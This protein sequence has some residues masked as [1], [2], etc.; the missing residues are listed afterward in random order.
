MKRVFLLILCALTLFLNA[1]EEKKVALLFLTRSNLNHPELW[2]DWI[3]EEKYNVYNHAK[4]EVTDP[5]FSQF[6]IDE[7]QPNEWG[8]LIYAQ[9][10]LLRAAVKDPENYKF[11]FLSESTIPLRTS[12]EVYDYLTAEEESYMSWMR[13]WWPFDTKRILREF[14]REYHLGNH[15]WIILNR[16]HAEMFAEDDYWIHLAMR[17]I[18][19]DESYPSTFYNMSGVLGEFKNIFTTYVDFIHG[20]PYLFTLA[21]PENIKYLLDARNNTKGVYGE[22]YCLFAR[23]VAPEFPESVL[24]EIINGKIPK[25]LAESLPTKKK[26]RK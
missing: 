16:K 4:Y 3:D 21:T 14:P 7:T 25:P 13:I 5:W 22:Q 17:H 9:Q 10:A 24:R 6:R 11:V 15:Q 26:R 12:D 19:C 1:S 18:C 23:K 8:F 20:G 2:K